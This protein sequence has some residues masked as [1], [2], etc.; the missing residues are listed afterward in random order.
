MELNRLLII[1]LIF[2]TSCAPANADQA[3]TDYMSSRIVNPEEDKAAE[4]DRDDDGPLFINNEEL[5]QRLDINQSVTPE[6]TNLL[7]EQ[8]RKRIR[9]A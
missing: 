2:I 8:G 1:A 4:G 6:T 3:L 7:G 5:L 9:G